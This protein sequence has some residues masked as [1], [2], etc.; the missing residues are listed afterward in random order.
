MNK[1]ER[2]HTTYSHAPTTMIKMGYPGLGRLAILYYVTLDLSTVVF[3]H[4]RP[5]EPPVGLI[6][7]LFFV[8]TNHD[9][10]ASRTFHRNLVV[11]PTLGIIL[12]LHSGGLGEWL[13]A[14]D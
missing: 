7:L 9:R 6:G 8:A 2:Y 12:G 4:L 11:I 13:A 5:V 14:C 1:G 3:E 10:I